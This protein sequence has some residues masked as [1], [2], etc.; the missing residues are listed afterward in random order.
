[1]QRLTSQL[2]ELQEK[3]NYVNDSGEFHEVVSNSGGKFSHVPT[4]PARISSPRSMLS[5]DK[6]LQPETW[7]PSGLQENVFAN[8]RSTLESFSMP[9]QR[10]HPFMTPNAAGEAPALIS[11]GNTVAR[12]DETIGSTIPM[13]TFARRPPTISSFVPVDIP[14]SSMVG[15]Q[16][17]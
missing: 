1:M 14:Q 8:P 10:I 12:E 7:N 2:Q 4:Q 9:Y 15:Q 5:C 6:R 13:P 3:K 16:R 17:Q 11:T